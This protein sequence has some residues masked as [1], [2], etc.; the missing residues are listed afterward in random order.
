MRRRSLLYV[1][2]IMP[3]ARGNGLAMRAALFLRALAR[4]HDVTLLV[5]PVAGDAEP[6]AFARRHARRIATVSL[7]GTEDPLWTLCARITDPAA[8][9]AA[10]A[11]YPRPALCRFATSPCLD[12]ARIAV[13]AERF[14][15]IHVGRTY[16]AAY[17]APFLAAPARGARPFAS[18]DLDDDEP[19][20][21][22]R[23]AA[24]HAADGRADDARVETAEADK[25]ER[26][27]AQWL[28]QFDLCYRCS[29]LDA[30][31]TRARMPSGVVAVAPNAVAIPW[32]AHRVRNVQRRLLF[33]GNLS[34]LPNVDGLRRFVTTMLP[35]IRAALGDTIVLRVAG[36]RPTPEVV[37]LAQ[38]QGV[39]LVANPPA[40]GMHYRWADVAIVPLVAGGG[41]R[42][43][44]IEAL[45]YAVPVVATPLGAEGLAV[46]DGVDVR[47]ADAG[48][49]FTDAC[50]SV[51][52]DAPVARRL[53]RAGRQL[54]IGRYASAA[55]ERAI[56]DAHVAAWAAST[57]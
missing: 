35:A 23:L 34:Y 6:T 15:A 51:L 2:P 31:A 57:R 43:K 14:D 3:A 16:L 55:G 19:A 40:I 27:E 48:P 41:T 52:A 13:G 17:A 38:A 11:A 46:T 47:L 56:R 54:A 26:H 18:I 44:L 49:A 5:V 7:A 30:A 9:A 53:G 10:F 25:Y 42:I 8:R 29:D 37:A 12:A 24:L 22:R 50:L 4:D 1:A 39:Q 20:T 28:P 33:V 36:S 45:A 21:H 32:L